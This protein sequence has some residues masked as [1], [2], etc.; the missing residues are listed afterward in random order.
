MNE[1]NFG[2]KSLNVSSPLPCKKNKNS[3]FFFES[4]IRADT[5]GDIFGGDRLLK[6]IFFWF[7]A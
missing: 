3:F 7:R 1:H 2:I 6:R 5:E 4:F